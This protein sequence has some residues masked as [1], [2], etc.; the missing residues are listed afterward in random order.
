MGKEDK[1]KENKRRNTETKVREEEGR[2]IG[3]RGRGEE[4]W[5]RKIGR[6][7]GGR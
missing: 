6:E 2:V 3:R 7:R 5:V 1:K 4:R